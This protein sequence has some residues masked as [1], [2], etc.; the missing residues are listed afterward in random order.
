MTVLAKSLCN[1]LYGYKHCQRHPTPF[2][3]L[4][5]ILMYALRALIRGQL[6]G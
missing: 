2:P 6:S 3:G 5:Q 1:A 4:K